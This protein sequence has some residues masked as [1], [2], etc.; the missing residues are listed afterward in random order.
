MRLGR[1]RWRRK[2]EDGWEVINRIRAKFEADPDGFIDE[3][4]EPTYRQLALVGKV[5]QLYAYADFCA[6]RIID[7][8]KEAAEGERGRNGSNL[9]EKQVL[10]HLRSAAELL[11]DCQLKEGLLRAARTL[12]MHR[13]NR[14]TLAHYAVRNIPGE[15]ALLVLNKYAREHEK[16][17][18]TRPD[19][20]EAG[21]G[22]VPLG[23]LARELKKLDGHTHMLSV[24]APRL[25]L[26]MDELT[27]LI[28]DK[29]P[30]NRR[31][32]SASRARSN[33]SS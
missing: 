15:H 1:F 4:T 13:G 8:I 25:E 24:V 21:Y 31:R 27:E 32:R 18:G 16:R 9:T 30:P 3:T 2:R 14:H 20:F 6:R 10:E 33:P 11:K 23:P 17:S 29:R 28:E 7:C 5:I 26:G 12:E 19:S 22:I